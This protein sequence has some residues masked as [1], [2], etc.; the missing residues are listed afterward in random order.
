[1]PNNTLILVRHAE[2]KVD[3]NTIISNWIL[4]E[5]GQKDAINLFRLELFNDVDIIITSAEEK[6]F[7]TANAL[8]K[9]LHKKVLRDEKLNEISRDKGRYL[10]TKDEYLKTLKLCVTN[11][12]QSYN[13]WETSNH[14]L[15][16][17]SKAIHE[18]DSRFLKKKILIVAH[19]GVLNLYFA[20]I[21]EQ[22]DIVFERMLTNTFCDYGIIQNSKIIK[23]IAKIQN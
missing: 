9:R 16:R 10:R 23:D 7:Q 14:A 2:T 22:L 3:E 19:G 5:K 8:S 18:I 15:E 13:N 11:R 4:T 21:I 6:S 17:F 20:K 12:T 1:M